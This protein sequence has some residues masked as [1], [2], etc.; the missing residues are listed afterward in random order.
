MKHSTYRLKMT[1]LWILKGLFFLL[2]APFSLVLL[3]FD[4]LLHLITLGRVQPTT[5]EKFTSFCIWVLKKVHT[6]EIALV[7]KRYPL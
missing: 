4:V 1:G 2:T 6:R 7:F 3:V 5:T